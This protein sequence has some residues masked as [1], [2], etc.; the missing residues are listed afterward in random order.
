MLVALSLAIK[1]VI[2][3]NRNL[4]GFTLIELLIV[5]AILAILGGAILTVLDP[6]AQRAKASQSAAKSLTRQ[7]CTNVAVCNVESSTGSC[8]NISAS[9]APTMNLPAGVSSGVNTTTTVSYT[10]S[11]GSGASIKQCTFTCD[12]SGNSTITKSSANSTCL[13]D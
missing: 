4:Q 13:I 8:P 6:A 3:R 9:I 2:M 12:V 10:S 1:I 5:I 11:M 7:A